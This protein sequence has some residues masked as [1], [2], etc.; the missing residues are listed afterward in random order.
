MNIQYDKLTAFAVWKGGERKIGVADVTLPDIEY[1]SE[2][3]KGAGIAGEVDMPTLGHT[4]SMTVSVNWRTI[5][6][7]NI[8]LIAPKAHDL[9]FRGAQQNYEA[10]GGELVVQSVKIN[11]RALPKKGGIG[12]LDTAAKTDSS[13][14]L[15]CVYLKVTIDGVVK[16]EIDKFNYIHNIAGTDYLEKVRA[17]LGLI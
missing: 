4:S 16:I 10:G 2:S 6:G 9:E 14:E 17:A 3:I 7:D 12:K 1:M 8:D 15:E 5:N 11:V 13:N